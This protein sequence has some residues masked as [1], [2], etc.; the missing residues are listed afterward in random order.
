MGSGAECGPS[1]ALNR[2]SA[3]RDL[4]ILPNEEGRTRC[5][6]GARFSFCHPSTTGDLEVARA[7]CATNRNRKPSRLKFLQ[8]GRGRPKDSLRR[9]LNGEGRMEGLLEVLQNRQ[10]RR[11][12]SSTGQSVD[13]WLGFAG[14]GTGRVCMRL[15]GSVSVRLCVLPHS[16]DLALVCS[17]PCESVFRFKCRGNDAWPTN[18]QAIGS[19]VSWDCRRGRAVKV[20]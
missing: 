11:P 9:L 4:H 13:A 2:S 5:A 8:V 7:K 15:G 14:I 6:P 16:E 10:G 1:P 12:N 20:P 19:M 3:H 18:G 17:L